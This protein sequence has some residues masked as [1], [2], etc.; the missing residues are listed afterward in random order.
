MQQARSDLAT[1]QSQGAAA[2]QLGPVEDKVVTAELRYENLR[3]QVLSRTLAPNAVASLDVETL[4]GAD[5]AGG[6]LVVQSTGAVRVECSGVL[7][8]R[9]TTLVLILDSN[10]LTGTLSITNLSATTSAAVR[11]TLGAQR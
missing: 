5:V 3:A 4:L 10:V 11:F 6:V 8:A 2:D 1:L 9:G 7:D